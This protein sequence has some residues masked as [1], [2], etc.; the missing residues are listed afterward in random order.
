VPEVLTTLKSSGLVLGSVT[1]GNSD[2][3]K[4]PILNELFSFGLRAEDCGAAKPDPRPF[5]LGAQACGFSEAEVL[6]VGDDYFGDVV[7]ASNVGMHAVW[8]NRKGE[9]PPGDHA[10]A[11]VDCVSNILPVIEPWI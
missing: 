6:Y 5:I 9:S 3:R 11:V 7:G 10:F 1:N 2:I 4:I 8:V